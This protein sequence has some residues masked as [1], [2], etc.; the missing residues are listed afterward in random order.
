[1]VTSHVIEIIC[2]YVAYLKIVY[3]FIYSPRSHAKT[4]YTTD[5]AATGLV[6][7]KW[8]HFTTLSIL[9]FSGLTHSIQCR[10][11]VMSLDDTEASRSLMPLKST[12][13]QRH[14]SQRKC[15]QTTTTWFIVFSETHNPGEE[16]QG[17]AEGEGTEGSCRALTR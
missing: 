15:R 7:K 3:G 12:S 6:T 14:F 5:R 10:L 13:L 2:N 17:N 1:M 11:F 8:N 16:G 4:T 9:S